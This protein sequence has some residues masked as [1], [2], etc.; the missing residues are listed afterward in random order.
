MFAVSVVV[1]CTVRVC[2]M[3]F[4][5]EPQTGFFYP[6][7]ETAGTLLTLLYIAMFAATAVFAY[8]ELRGLVR[9]S[10]HGVGVGI[11]SVVTAVLIAVDGVVTAVTATV[12]SPQLV[13]G[14][15]MSGCAVVF[16][17]LEALALLNVGQELRCWMV[18]FPAIYWLLEALFRFGNYMKMA[19][20]SENL[21][22]IA[23]L[24]FLTLFFLLYAKSTNGVNTAK[25]MRMMAP[26]GYCT[27]LLCILCTLPRL[28][29]MLLADGKQ[30]HETTTVEPLLLVMAVLVLLLIP[31]RVKSPDNAA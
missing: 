8:T 2:Q 15:L 13:M 19:T 4:M 31:R 7:Y 21:F 11:F 22:D 1:S 27:S 12:V 18:A 9:R 25:S 29:V 6:G 14:I 23:A 26:V 30:L 24:S 28:A 10:S 3:L 5:T 16:F 17:V 20:I